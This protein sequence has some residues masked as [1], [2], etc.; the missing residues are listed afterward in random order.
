MVTEP[1]SNPLPAHSVW[2]VGPC[3]ALH[4][5]DNVRDAAIGTCPEGLDAGWSDEHTEG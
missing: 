1:N 4:M 5:V 3:G 2:W